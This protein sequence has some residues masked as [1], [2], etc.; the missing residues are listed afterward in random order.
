MRCGVCHS[1]FPSRSQLYLHRNLQ[2]GGSQSEPSD[3]KHALDETNEKLMQVYNANKRHIFGNVR[4]SKGAQLY[5]FPVNEDKLSSDHIPDQLRAIE[6]NQDQTFKVNMALGL[7]L[8]KRDADKFR[9]YIP[10]QNDMVLDSPH[11]VSS[12][13][14]TRRLV[15]RL[16]DINFLEYAKLHSPNSKWEPYM[17]TNVLYYVYPTSFP[18]GRGDLPDFVK[19]CR[20]IVTLHR[21]AHRELFSGNLCAFRALAC[22]ENGGERPQV[23]EVTRLFDQWRAF[24]G[25]RVSQK[26]FK[27]IELC[28]IPKFEE[29]FKVNVNVYEMLSDR[30]IVPRYR[31]EADYDDTIYLNLY[32][33]HLSYIQNFAQ[34]AMKYQCP[35]CER[36]FNRLNDWKRHVK[37]CKSKTKSVFPGGFFESKITVFDELEQ[38]CDIKIDRPEA[39]YPYFTVFDFESVLEEE[40]IQ[41]SENQKITHKHRPV[42][43]SICSNVPGFTNAK[44]LIDADL[45]SLLTSMLKYM[46]EIAQKAETLIRQKWSGVLDDL[47]ELQRR[48]TKTN[49]AAVGCDRDTDADSF[50]QD[51][52]AEDE[53]ELVLGYNGDSVDTSESEGESTGE[54]DDDDGRVNR[55]KPKV[56]KSDPHYCIAQRI[57]SVASRFDLYCSQMPVLSF[58]GARYDLN[59]IKSKLV[60]H[61]G[62][63]ED[64]KAF[65]I[66]KSNAY[67]CIANSQF[68]FMDICNWLSPCNL[69]GFHK[70]FDVPVED[71]KDTFAYEWFDDIAKLDSTTFPKYEDFFSSL[72]DKNVL[73]EGDE[74][75]ANYATLK[76]KFNTEYKT[77]RNWLIDYAN[78]D[79]GPTCLAVENMLKFYKDKQVDVFKDTISSPGV[80][81]ILMFRSTNAKFPLFDKN[82]EDIFRMVQA[83]VFGGPAQVFTRLHQVGNT[84]IRS[85][86]DNICQNILGYD[87]NALYPYALSQ[88]FPTGCLIDRKSEND[89]KPKPLNKF[90]D[91]YYWMDHVAYQEG[92]HIK[93]RLNNNNKEVRIGH[94]PVDGFRQVGDRGV[95]YE[96]NGCWYHPHEDCSLV[97]ETQ[98]EKWRKLVNQRKE[99]T[100]KKKEYLQSLGYVVV[101]IQECD[102]KA[103][104]ARH[105]EQHILDQYMPRVDNVPSCE[106]AMLRSILSEEVFGMALC[107]IEVPD[108]WQSD[109]ERELLGLE[110]IARD[111]PPYEYFGEMCPI[112]CTADVDFDH[113]GEHMQ[114]YARSANTSQN[115]RR[116][117]IGGMKGKNLL[118]ATPLL[119]WYMKAGLV[120]RKLHRVIQAQPNQCFKGFVDLACKARREG[121]VDK[122]KAII[123]DT[124]KKIANSAY[125][126]LLMN[127]EKHKSHVYVRGDHQMKLKVNDPRFRHLSHLDEDIYEI[128]M[129][130]SKTKYDTCTLLGYYVLQL[131]KLHMLRW[132]YDWLDVFV[133]RSHFEMATMDTDSCYFAIAGKSLVDVIRP[134]LKQQYIDTIQNSCHIDRIEADGNFWFPRTCCREHALF[135]KRTPG[136]MKLEASGRLMICLAAKTYFLANDSGNKMSCK[137]SNKQ[138]MVDPQHHYLKALVDKASHYSTNRG[139]KATETGVVTYE[140][141]KLAFSYF[142]CK[143][144]VLADGIHTKPLSLSLNPISLGN[145]TLINYTSSLS[146]TYEFLL[147]VD[148]MSF[149][150]LH[151][152]FLH[153][154]AKFH[155]QLELAVDIDETANYFHLTNKGLSRQ[156][157]VSPEWMECRRVIMYELL[158]QKWLQCERF[159]E[160]LAQSD[161]FIVCGRDNFWFCGMPYHVAIY[162]KPVYHPGRNELGALLQKLKQSTQDLNFDDVHY[163]LRLAKQED[164][165]A[166]SELVRQGFRQGPRYAIRQTERNYYSIRKSLK[167]LFV[168]VREKIE[169]DRAEQVDDDET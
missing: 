68:R 164:D 145:F 14:G 155:S 154:Q 78:K 125:G 138:F 17:I 149:H 93:H 123:A 7:I 58:N 160:D 54:G 66:K 10:Y 71:Q 75:R 32:E 46:S 45:D 110:P 163:F 51:S 74:G 50:V 112:F 36:Q 15:N 39:F 65:I 4:N 60:N 18:L 55:R 141:V 29:C 63:C 48:F 16:R 25:L 38:Q 57:S 89:F 22:H 47:K 11:V 143:R 64:K 37:I 5:N 56:D 165:E 87:A 136:L 98:L 131:S 80:A 52:D 61:L 127:K 116:L 67:M 12:R 95:V 97:Q 79:T 49:A 142:Y 13:S 99:R 144:E 158:L 115:P 134:E 101:D 119:C 169:L 118:L 35:C 34:Y 167:E 1:L 108:Q 21:N 102:Y 126:S 105:I 90:M 92:V 161:N 94:Y 43:V 122:S 81:R 147:E 140:L 62:L 113:I 166:V 83:N 114:E 85:N 88:S 153:R 8:K 9:Y 137:G 130:K 70:A 72:K 53:T 3:I 120:V 133:P 24:T 20:S 30:A 73:G 106:N 23:C 146:N 109:E 76:H 42:C 26:R 150:S 59:L 69:L 33:R 96:F 2:H 19:N 132:Y 124:W 111:M 82:S 168:V 121:D 84:A 152:C 157:E 31:S 41:V 104:I 156:L 91:M 162:S 151:Q 40:N 77:V 148:D 128:E 27:G 135:D 159:R 100:R 28:D 117:L 103:R 107:D 86:P 129:A 44:C 139:I 6:Q